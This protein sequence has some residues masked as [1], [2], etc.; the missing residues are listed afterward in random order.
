MRFFYSNLILMYLIFSY[1]VR[2]K[3]SLHYLE[4]IGIISRFVVVGTDQ[5]IGFIL[6]DGTTVKIP[7]RMASK[8]LS[9]IKI[10]DVVTVKGFRQTDRFIA[11]E[12]ITNTS[13]TAIVD[14]VESQLVNSQAVK[15]IA[16][17]AISN[18][19]SIR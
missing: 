19:S 13:T 4:K 8:I 2:S 10:D 6:H 9:V 3:A 1:S 16:D 11:A 17:S 15:K 14:E 5:V 18:P 12:S 7:Q